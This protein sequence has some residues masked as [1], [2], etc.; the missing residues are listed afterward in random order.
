MRARPAKAEAR[1]GI[2][3][4][5]ASPHHHCRSG[6]RAV[7]RDAGG[8][9]VPVAVARAAPARG[10]RFERA[11][12][13]RSSD[14]RRRHV[15]RGN[16][17]LHAPAQLG[18]RVL[19][20]GLQSMR[21][22]A[23]SRT[24]R[25]SRKPSGCWKIRPCRSTRSCNTCSAPTGRWRA[26]ASQRLRRRADRNERA[27]EVVAHFEKLYPWPIHFALAVPPR[28][29]AATGGGRSRGRRQGLVGRQS[30]RA[31]ALPRL[32]RRAES[33]WETRPCSVPR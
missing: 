26:S 30:D 22:R 14:L 15:G 21:T 29:R 2:R 24:N 19:A 1:R 3:G 9:E 33:G 11:P 4:L 6:R 28:R 25:T 18:G 27:D 7:A 20:P 5:G 17:A 10:D 12:I 23:S 13:H 31:R 8:L 32:L 16:V